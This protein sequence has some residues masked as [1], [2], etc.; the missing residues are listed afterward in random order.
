[1]GLAFQ[2]TYGQG[3]TVSPSSTSATSELGFTNE[4][5]VF[6]NLGN[7]ICYIRVGPSNITADAHDY[8]IL[9][10]SQVSIG[11]D[12]DDTHVAYYSPGSGSLHIISGIGL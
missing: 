10:G 2:P 5:M 3:I 1:M 11:K 4:T 9:P 12:Q 7:V 6:T 8:P